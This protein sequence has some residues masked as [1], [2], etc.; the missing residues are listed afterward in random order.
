MITD[1]PLSALL[2]GRSIVSD[3]S[4]MSCL[5]L[6][7][8]WLYECTTSHSACGR[9]EMQTLPTRVINVGTEEPLIHPFLWITGGATGDW[10]TLSHCWGGVVP[11]TTT[12]ATLTQRQTAI[13][14]EELPLTFRDAINFTRKLGFQ[15]IWIDSLCIVQDSHEDWT[16]ESTKMCKIYKNASL[17][18]S[19]SAASDSQEGLFSTGNKERSLTRSIASF[20]SSSKK[21]NITGMVEIRP[22]TG[23]PP[24][25]FI[26][27]EPLHKRAWVSQ[28]SILSPR[29]ID[30]GSSQLH[31]Y[32][33]STQRTEGFPGS[34]NSD[35]NGEFGA[36][37]LFEMP[38][39][40][41]AL[42]IPPEGLPLPLKHPL[43][44]WYNNL[45]SYQRRC[46]TIQDDILPAIAGIAEQVASRTAYN[47]KAGLWLEDMH[48]GLLWQSWGAARRISNTGCPSWS[49]GST[50]LPWDRNRHFYLN[51]SED[52]HRWAEILDVSVTNAGD[53]VFGE[54]IFSA[55]T[56]HGACKDSRQWSTK[57]E[58]VF[59]TTDGK[60]R[61]AQLHNRVSE[62]V[63]YETGELEMPPPGKIICTLDDRPVYDDLCLE[64]M[65]AQK[66]ICIQ[67]AKFGHWTGL[68]GKRQGTTTFGLLLQPTGKG[69]SEYSRI[70]I[71]EIPDENGLAESW[72][73]K[74]VTII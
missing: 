14:T 34:I 19:A 44:W 28:E 6:V 18:I 13:F 5:G 40:T 39:R 7:R 17:N 56:L 26:W 36:K 42:E 23:S 48:R 74:I 30:F 32:C 16:I 2:P 8:K 62:P 31:W 61:Y 72:D 64:E 43:Y 22:Y 66:V 24:F 15:Y 21:H 73:W 10:V 12:L 50:V 60:Y 54:V 4:S 9:K 65:E 25:K 33:L 37:G 20:R 35:F 53:N 29:R 67:I 3:S 51:S 57:S 49:W 47:Y 70:G 1:D 58:A 38:L 41:S 69:D 45:R 63:D 59:N 27:D 52:I 11:L 68:S 55:L 46:I 71:A